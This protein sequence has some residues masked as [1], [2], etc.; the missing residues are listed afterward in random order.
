MQ[1]F[2]PAPGQRA[3]SG[4]NLVVFLIYNK[5]NDDLMATDSKLASLR[6]FGKKITTHRNNQ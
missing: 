1:V 5:K 4:A 6:I 3:Y 2:D